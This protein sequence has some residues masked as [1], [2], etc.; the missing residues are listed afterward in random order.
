MNNLN[1]RLAMARDGANVQTWSNGGTIETL[2]MFEM[3]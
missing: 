1:V 3:R 2:F